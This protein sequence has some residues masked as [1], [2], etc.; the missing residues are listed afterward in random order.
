MGKSIQQS[1]SKS[2][3]TDLDQ[4]QGQ[5]KLSTLFRYSSRCDKILIA[6]GVICSIIS[7]I[8]FPLLS[9]VFGTLMDGFINSHPH[10]MT[11]LNVSTPTNSSSSLYFSQ[12]QTV[13]DVDAFRVEAFT[14]SG[15]ILG[16]AVIYFMTVSIYVYTLNKV[17]QNQSFRIKKAFIKQVLNLDISHI[18]KTPSL[19]PGSISTTLL[20]NVVKIE[21]G[22]GESIGNVISYSTV[23]LC[24]I[25]AS[26]IISWKLTLILLS[27][28]PF[29]IA[30]IG[31]VQW[32]SSY[33]SDK[34]RI[35]KSC[36]G[37]ICQESF[38][39]IR[40]VTAFNGQWSEISR[41]NLVSSKIKHCIDRSNFFLGFGIGMFLL[42]T[43]ISYGLGIYVG[44]KFM[45]EKTIADLSLGTILV[46]FWNIAMISMMI[47]TL[48]PNIESIQLAVGAASPLF[49]IID[50]ANMESEGTGLQD[51]PVTDIVIE[52]VTFSY[53]SRPDTIVLN[54]VTMNI[55]KGQT[56][57]LVG[58]SGSGKSSLL[59][60][61][62]R[63]YDV[64]QGEI[65]ISGKSIKSWNRTALKNNIAVVGQEPVLFEGTIA[66]NI[67][68]GRAY[69]GEDINEMDK[70]VDAAKRSHSHDF[71]NKLPSGYQT[72][73]T[74]KVQLSGGQ[75]QRIAIARALIKQ[76]S[77]L[78]LDEATSALD[79][80]SSALVNATIAK[81]RGS[82]ED[83]IMIIVAHKL[84][85]IKA[86]DMIYVFQKGSIVESGTHSELLSMNGLYND[87]Y[88]AQESGKVD[89]T[90]QDIDEDME[91][92]RFGRHIQS[93][94]RSLRKRK[95]GKRQ[96]RRT[97]QTN[98]QSIEDDTIMEK[99]EP[100]LIVTT[101]RKSNMKSLWKMLMRS[102]FS[103]FLGI[104]STIIAGFWIPFYAVL[105]G[106][107][108]SIM[109]Y[110][111]D[112]DT[113][114]SEATEISWKFVIAGFI[115]FSATTLSGYFFGKV[116]SNLSNDI[117]TMVFNSIIHKP[118]PWFELE[119]NN[120]GSLIVRIISH[121]DSIS[122]YANE[123]FPGLIQNASTLIACVIIA[124]FHSWKLTAVV[125]T[126]VPLHFV[127]AFYESRSSDIE[128]DPHKVSDLEA[129]AKLTISM[130]EK[131]KTINC[132]NLQDYFAGKFDELAQTMHSKNRK[133]LIVRALIVGASKATLPLIFSVTFFVASHWISTGELR[134]DQFLKITEGLLFACFIIAEDSISA[135]GE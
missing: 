64:D 128:Y 14:A 116:S 13:I 6:V 113:K 37:A 115:V 58:P 69:R 77:I 50:H 46:I 42:L 110:D 28:T 94:R 30:S 12:E 84:E 3:L 97:F 33:Y 90:N 89:D 49:Q 10:N 18:E 75:K 60:L 73:L 41:F 9:V 130:I 67:V 114:L 20:S 123:K 63:F 72:L 129:M 81:E 83:R 35:I 21:D 86:A 105:L 91:I 112:D 23:I 109:E 107:F 29:I 61:L 124:I 4:D 133:H 88:N 78:L 121:A 54:N 1:E 101:H 24:K 32:S 85:D 45:V 7:G 38:S 43:M 19:S 11:V 31:I 82:M 22:I 98:I 100:D 17:A 127:L 79:N 134:Y 36:L 95:S 87:M 65:L 26:L 102:R 99:T 56:V 47:V 135:F 53:P 119:E 74:D 122:E 2:N 117:R 131:I 118:I 51:I 16:M 44:T 80:E 52:N 5:I 120:V 92:T 15:I 103:L 70:I 111:D 55:Q 57:A 8:M 40:T 126:F 59:E 125:L 76:S 132:F 27:L 66:E 48:S 68:L 34:Q 96:L 104:M 39:M 71:V 108:T 62:Q 25:L 106:D 93:F